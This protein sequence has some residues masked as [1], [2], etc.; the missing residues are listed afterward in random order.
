[1]RV[2]VP[3]TVRNSDSVSVVCGCA[4]ESLVSEVSGGVGP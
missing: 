4:C 3:G 1:M 2:R